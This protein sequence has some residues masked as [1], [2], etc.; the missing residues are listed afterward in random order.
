MFKD[1]YLIMQVH[2]FASQDIIKAAYKKLCHM[3]HPDRGGDLRL[4]QDINEAYACLTDVEKAEAYK[5]TWLKHYIHET[6]FDFGAL[7][8]SLYDISMHHVKEVLMSYLNNIKLGDYESAYEL[9]SKANKE[10]I[11][12][13]D[14]MLWQKLISEVHHLLDF[15]ANF[16]AFTNNETGL[17]VHYKVRVREFNILMNH[18]EI[19]YFTRQL[20]YEDN[21]W[22]LLIRDIDVRAVIRKYKKILAMNRKN[23][24]KYLHKIDENHMTKHISKKYLI[25][26]SE[27]ER[28]RHLR[29]GNVFSLL[30]CKSSDKNLEAVIE[31]ETRQLDCFCDYGKDQYL[32]LM[33]ETSI[34][35]GHTVA[36]KIASKLKEPLS[37][38]IKGITEDLTIKELVNNLCRSN[39]ETV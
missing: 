12:R 1:Y 8:P 37:Y 13:K 30:L 17:I 36:R 3:H 35:N 25:N 38:A 4:F 23:I 19:D 26:N 27:Y 16:D 6:S 5:K 15:D 14:F 21:T 18:V 32:I 2:Y 24:K 11:F 31:N 20:I 7:Q 29:Y 10:K 39:Y 22:R 9:I 28:L 33:P 34:E